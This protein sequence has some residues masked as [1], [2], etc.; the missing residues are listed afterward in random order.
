MSRCD[1]HILPGLS[2]LEPLRY[3]VLG[4]SSRREPPDTIE[5]PWRH[6]ADRGLEYTLSHRII[7]RQGFQYRKRFPVHTLTAA[8]VDV[9]W[10]LAMPDAAALRHLGRCTLLDWKARKGPALTV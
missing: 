1:R 5:L 9:F 6:W 7:P 2:A 10:P 4:S 3:R 8:I